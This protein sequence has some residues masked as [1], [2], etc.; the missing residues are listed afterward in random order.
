MAPRSE[1]DLAADAR[2]ARQEGFFLAL[3]EYESSKMRSSVQEHG[4]HGQQQQKQQKQKQQPQ[5]SGTGKTRKGDGRSSL[6]R[7]SV[8]VAQIPFRH[9]KPE[10]VFAKRDS[11]FFSLGPPL[12]KISLN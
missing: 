2:T 4:Q 3:S 12:N 9:R 5:Q 6:V 7:V 10:S 1:V 11:Q 8:P